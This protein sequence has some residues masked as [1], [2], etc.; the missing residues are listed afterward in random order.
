MSYA[1]KIG[2]TEVIWIGAR[3]LPQG[4]VRYAGEVSERMV[5]DAVLGNV[6]LMTRDELQQA[7]ADESAKRVESDT[8]RADA[9]QA[10]AALETIIAIAP[11][12]TT[13]QMRAGMEQMARIIKH[14][15]LATVGR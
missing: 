14:L 12:A 11:T 2:T 8:A 5:W 13:A 4:Y 3:A 10:I 1:A 6:R 15:I 9:K 7:E